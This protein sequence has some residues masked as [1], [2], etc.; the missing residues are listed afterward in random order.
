M[1][2]NSLFPNK[3]K[4]QINKLHK[5]KNQNQNKKKREKSS[6]KHIYQTID[7]NLLFHKFDVKNYDHHRY[8]RSMIG[9][10]RL[11]SIESQK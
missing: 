2:E 10:I 5:I 8:H 7:K 6:K 1:Y 11:A 4:E 9:K 3:V